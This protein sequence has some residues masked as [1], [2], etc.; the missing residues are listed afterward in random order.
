MSTANRDL[1]TDLA[2][3]ETATRALADALPYTLL[4]LFW[5]WVLEGEAGDH[6][7]AHS[8]LHDQI[9]PLLAALDAIERL[10]GE[11]YAA[12]SNGEWAGRMRARREIDGFRARLALE[13]PR[14]PGQ[15]VA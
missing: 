6:A 15:R 7:A 3:V 8:T 13:A 10:N 1:I 11:T 12:R 4:D 2:L 14:T 9:K 5:R